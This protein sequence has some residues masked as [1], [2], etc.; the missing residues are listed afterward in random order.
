MQTPPLTSRPLRGRPRHALAALLLAGAAVLSAFAFSASLHAQAAT[1]SWTN[2]TSAINGDPGS[3]SGSIAGAP[4][5]SVTYSGQNIG[6]STDYPSWTPA[7]TFTGGTVGNAP[8]PANNAVDLTGGD[9][10][11]NTLTFST[12]V[13]NPILAI[14]S[15][16]APGLPASFF[17][18]PDEPFTIEAGGPN[19]EYD[20]ST[21]TAVGNEILGSE[22]NGVVQFNGTFSS[23]SWTNPTY[24][25][26]YAFTVGITAVTSSLAQ[27]GT[28]QFD[29]VSYNTLE[30]AASF[31][32]TVH[33]TG[34][35]TGA[36]SVMYGTA[37][38]TAATGTD[39]TAT[40]GTLTWADGD[41][42]DKTIT[43]PLIDH[44][45]Y[46]GSTR[47][48]TVSLSDPT[49]GAVSGATA[50]ASV[51]ILEN[52][53]APSSTVATASPV[54]G[55]TV[56]VGA[57]VPFAASVTDPGGILSA[58][59]FSI[60]GS[61]IYQSTG[62]GPFVTS[63]DTTLYP[64]GDYVV[65]ATVTDNQGGSNTSTVTVHLVAASAD[66]PP[67]TASVLTP[68][69]DPNG[70]PL[71]LPAGTTITV[72]FTAAPADGT[73]LQTV[74]LYA[75]GVL[76]AAFDGEGN[77]VTSAASRP[78]RRDASAT[79]GLDAIFQTPYTL[80]GTDKIVNL[81]AVALDA[82]GQSTVSNVASIHATVTDDKAPLLTLS[83]LANGAQV[84]LARSTRSA[85]ARATRTRR[86]AR[87]RR[88]SGGR[89]QPA[90]P[91]SPSWHTIST[92]CSIIRPSCRPSISTSPR[93][94]RASS[95]WT[96]WPRM[97]RGWRR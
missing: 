59:T 60:N 85:S 89:T 75:D 11:V 5:V 97:G 9:S 3:A 53:V 56:A 48:F 22:G 39:Y 8:P 32:L 21:I 94:R 96:W 47:T 33:R 24:E 10:T 90:T 19:A 20:G 67:P 82:L 61:Q 58:V 76:V 35:S 16:G 37:D 43:V 92:A 15:L 68:L 45:L 55:I 38:A 80:P 57:V 14:W 50:V 84:R 71:N 17:F 6:L 23:L 42:T 36:V 30:N 79:P 18:T 49:G 4:A 31:T 29:R 88:G 66:S 93:P 26:Y 52:N 44:Q 13:T 12:P 2:W 63:V 34:G 64:P 7:T 95:N 73:T 41:A 69:L 46:D 72:S 54:D 83:G 86:T 40:S 70:Q 91:R 81:I 27:P 1:I 25:G 51:N 65:A 28:L 78:V 87:W 74:S 77:P 62:G